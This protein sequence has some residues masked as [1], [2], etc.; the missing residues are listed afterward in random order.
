MTHRKT[1][2]G[3]PDEGQCVRESMAAN[4]VTPNKDFVRCFIM[5][6]QRPP[7]WGP[8]MEQAL[9][10]GLTAAGCNVTRCTCMAEHPVVILRFKCQDAARCDTATIRR[11]LRRV[12]RE[13]G[14]NISSG[15]LNCV[16]RQWKVE[17]ELV[18]TEPT[19]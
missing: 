18:L 12:V 3:I 11:L 4:L 6:H 9:R 19:A 10:E 15:G 16:L 7:P 1:E 14:S 5:A 8:M 2:M 13:L 17:A